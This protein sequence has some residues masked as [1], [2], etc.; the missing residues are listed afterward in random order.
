MPIFS[1][2]EVVLYPEPLR[3]VLIGAYAKSRGR[4]VS[5][6]KPE[7]F[8]IHGSVKLPLFPLYLPEDKE[9]GEIDGI[10]L[11]LL[12]EGTLED[13]S[14]YIKIAIGGD[15]R[16]TYYGIDESFEKELEREAPF[17]IPIWKRAREISEDYYSGKKK[18]AKKKWGKLREEIVSMERKE[19]DFLKA[20]FC[21]PLFITHRFEQVDPVSVHYPFVVHF[22]SIKR[23]INPERLASR[24]ISLYNFERLWNEEKTKVITPF[25]SDVS[26]FT[27]KVVYL[28]KGG[29]RLFPSEMDGA[30][31]FCRETSF[32]CFY[33][34][35]LPHLSNEEVLTIVVFTPRSISDE[36]LMYAIKTLAPSVEEGNIEIIKVIEDFKVTIVDRFDV[37]EMRLLIPPQPSCIS[38]ELKDIYTISL[39]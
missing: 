14:S 15:I 19:R 1:K 31:I 6:E 34:E 17:S 4:S 11:S 26:S 25:N 13:D 38:R 33:F 5:V 29:R 10:S 18:E 35:S 21:S 2:K 30:V 36:D 20:V 23:V 22:S 3:G 37:K 28:I 8:F 32:E 24:I 27:R 7:F 12:D 9:G 16:I 39:I